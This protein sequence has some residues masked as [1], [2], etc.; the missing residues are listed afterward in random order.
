MVAQAM[1]QNKKADILN[2][3]GVLKQTKMGE[4]SNNI[5]SEKQIL[6]TELNV[7]K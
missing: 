4:I 1:K 3:E 6:V 2:T 5:I 7:L